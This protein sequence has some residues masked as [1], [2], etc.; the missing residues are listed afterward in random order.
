MLDQPA[1][2]LGRMTAAGNVYSAWRGLTMAKNKV[3]WQESHAEAW[4][5]CTSV[6]KLRKAN[7]Q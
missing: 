2:M 7:G 4:E 3:E 5:V 1:G 6:M